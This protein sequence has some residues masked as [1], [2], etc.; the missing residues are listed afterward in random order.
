MTIH[1][2]KANNIRRLIFL[3]LVF[4][5]ITGCTYHVPQLRAFPTPDVAPNGSEEGMRCPNLVF[6]DEHGKITKLQD[7][8]GKIIFMNFWASWCVPCQ[9]EMPSLQKLYDTLGRNEGI[10]FLF[11]T[12][13]KD[14]DDSKRWAKSNGYTIPMYRRAGGP[15]L[16]ISRIPKTMILDRNGIIVMSIANR[17][18]WDYWFESI[19]DLINTSVMTSHRH[20]SYPADGVRVT[21]EVLDSKPNSN[22]RLA[23][24]PEKG[25]KLSAKRG[26]VLTPVAGNTV[27]WVTPMPVTR[28]Q[29]DIDYFSDTPELALSF[30]S[31]INPG[32]AALEIEYGYCKANSE[33]CVPAKTSIEVPIYSQN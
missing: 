28:V 11:F 31:S 2:S 7:Y 15:G 25:V 18:P 10:V 13:G 30:S 29:E 23:L 24:V 20:Y 4:I 8:R 22:L 16:E 5:P 17:Q 33:Q 14:F 32:I 1:G 27:R 26:I 9:Q 3:I 12:L 21:V 19:Q 6:E